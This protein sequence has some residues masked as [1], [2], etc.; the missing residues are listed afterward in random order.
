MAG[1]EQQRYRASR[2]TLVTGAIILW[3][4][5]YME[6]AVETLKNQGIKINDDWYQ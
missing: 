4:T 2:L 1:Y 3:N 6:R 5:V